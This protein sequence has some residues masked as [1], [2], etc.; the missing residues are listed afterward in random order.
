M[1]QCHYDSQKTE[2]LQGLL[3]NILFGEATA[4]SVEFLQRLI[5]SYSWQ[6]LHHNIHSACACTGLATKID[7]TFATVGEDG[8]L[9]V[10]CVEHREPVREI[11]K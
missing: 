11:S 8:R 4:K 5:T 3:A 10:M 2:G 1:L 9:N 7:D 6:G